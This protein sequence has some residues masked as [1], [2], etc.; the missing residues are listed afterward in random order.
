MVAGRP[1]AVKG[2]PASRASRLPGFERPEGE[3]VGA[4]GDGTA[5]AEAR[6]ADGGA[7]VR[8]VDDAAGGPGDGDGPRAGGEEGAAL[9]LVLEVPGRQLQ[10]RD[11]AAG[12][13]LQAAVQLADQRRQEVRRRGGKAAADRSEEHTSELQSHLNLVCRLLL[14]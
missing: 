3:G 2:Q 7:L 4:K 12:E 13:A 11:V 9:G 5:G 1:G 8:I 14:E 10:A 6:E